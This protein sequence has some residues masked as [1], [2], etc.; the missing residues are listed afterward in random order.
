MV[1][2][3]LECLEGYLHVPIVCGGV[4]ESLKQ[5]NLDYDLSC[6]TKLFH[7]FYDRETNL[8][9]SILLV[10]NRLDKEA[11]KPPIDASRHSLTM[12]VRIQTSESHFRTKDFDRPVTLKE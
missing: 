2:F 5:M 3:I 4:N 12:P 10:R 11:A 8:V 6:T 7:L 1:Y 9:L